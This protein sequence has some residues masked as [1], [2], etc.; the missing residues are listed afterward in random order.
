[1]QCSSLRGRGHSRGVEEGAIHQG[2][3][4]AVLNQIISLTSH[5]AFLWLVKDLSCNSIFGV[6]EIDY[7]DV[8]HQHCRA[9]NELSYNEE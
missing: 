7:M 1:M 3:I 4:V 9:R 2:A 5:D 8:K 6:V